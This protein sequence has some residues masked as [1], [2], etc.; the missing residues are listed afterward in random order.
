L[1]RAAVRTGEYSD[2]AA[3]KYLGDVL[4]KRRDKIAGIYLTALNPVVDPRLDASGRLTFTNAA[5]AAGVARDPVTY[6]VAWSTFDNTTGATTAL[7]TAQSGTPGFNAPAGLP[8]TVGS[9]IAVDIAAE[10]SEYATWKEPIHTHFRR[11][12]EG[13]KLVGLERMPDKVTPAAAS[14]R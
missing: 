14:G 12:A 13:W 6:R 7:M 11:T 10:S 8:T 4:I 5:I 2:P 3:E 9:M 1:I